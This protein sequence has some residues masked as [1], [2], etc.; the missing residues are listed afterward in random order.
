MRSL[1]CNRSV[2]RAIYSS[3]AIKAGKDIKIY[4]LAVPLNTDS[5]F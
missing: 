2:S 4:V 3:C 5:T 1:H